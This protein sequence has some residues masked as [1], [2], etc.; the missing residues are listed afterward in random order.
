MGVR[1]NDKIIVTGAAGLVGQNLITLLE[2]RGFSNIVAIDKNNYNLLVLH[3]RHPAVNT[4]LA[5]LTE[6]GLWEEHFR[7]AKVVITLHSQITAKHSAL[8]TR[9]NVQAMQK[10]VEATKHSGI[11]FLIHVSSSV[12][13]SVAEDDYTKTKRAQERLVMECGINYCILRPTL[14]FGW[15]DPKHLGWLAGFME[16][17]PF[18]PIPGHGRYVRQPLYNRDFCR[19]ILSCLERQPDGQVF[20]LVGPEQIDYIDM[21]RIIKKVKGLKTPI[22]KI[23]YW[24]FFVLLKTY[25]VF[26]KHPPFTADQ[27]K[28]LTAG[29]FFTGVDM[30]STFGI[31]PTPFELAIEETFRHPQYS[32]VVVRSES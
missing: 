28:A 25:S 9:N 20:N 27:L 30:E 3:R 2:E 15:F 24:L 16:K 31:R 7:E 21:I 26:S 19:V 8:F 23:P 22:V 29:D 14:M 32:C 11:P 13:N 4:V 1:P 6:S 10:V 5:D 17:V 12:V 18:F